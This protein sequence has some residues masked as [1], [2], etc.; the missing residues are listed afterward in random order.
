MADQMHFRNTS[1]TRT[2]IAALLLCLSIQT[3]SA[4]TNETAVKK[5]T[6][7]YS[8][9][10]PVPAPTPVDSR[11]QNYSVTLLDGG[12]S[13]FADLIGN[14]KIV[15]VNFWATWCAPCRREIPDLVNIQRELRGRGI[16]VLG[17]TVEDPGRD[18]DKVREFTQKYGINY[19]IG[20]SPMEMFMAVNG[21]DPR[22]V[23]PQTYIF[24]RKGK[25][26][27]SAR[28]F[29]RDFK[30][31]VLAVVEQAEKES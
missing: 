28:G 17:L 1:L 4:C 25:L 18:L 19:R 9:V 30:D 26:I 31:W 6:G 12:G 29:R 5:T 23:I 3:F 14:D 21:K 24:D 20:F 16:E 22:G 13:K 15:L 11:V 2:A 8:Y 7:G 27:D 10:P